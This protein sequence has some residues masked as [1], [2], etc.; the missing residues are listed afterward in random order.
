MTILNPGSDLREFQE[1]GWWVGLVLKCHDCGCVTV[2]DWSD[3]GNLRAFWHYT[4]HGRSGHG[5]VEMAC[6]NCLRVG[7]TSVGREEFHLRIHA[8]KAATAIG[9]LVIPP[10]LPAEALR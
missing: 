5:V 7:H 6:P 2:L 8:A 4:C 1:H 9:P 10:P 3:H